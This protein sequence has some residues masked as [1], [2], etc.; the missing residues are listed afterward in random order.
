MPYRIGALC[1]RSQSAFFMVACGN[2]KQR[3]IAVVVSLALSGIQVLHRIAGTDRYA[4]VE[5]SAVVAGIDKV[6]CVRP[7]GKV[8][9]RQRTFISTY[10]VVIV[11]VGATAKAWPGA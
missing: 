1:P 2:V 6:A 7:Y 11:S 4:L 3:M 9:R 5:S 10:T 8:Q